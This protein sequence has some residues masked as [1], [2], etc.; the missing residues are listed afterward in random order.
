MKNTC[1]KFGLPIALLTIGST[2]G[3]EPAEQSPTVEQKDENNYT[4]ISFGADVFWKQGSFEV[5]HPIYGPDRKY[6]GSYK[7][8]GKETTLYEGF[9]YTSERIEPNAFYG[10]TNILFAIGKSDRKGYISDQN[11]YVHGKRISHIKSGSDLWFNMDAGLGYSFQPFGNPHFLLSVFAGPGFHYER[12]LH[13]HADW[14]YAMAGF[15]IAQDLTKSLSLG[16]DFKTMYSF[17]VD[18]PH[19]ETDF[20]RKG[21]RQFCGIELG[22]PLTWHFGETRK[23][24]L[25][26]KPYLLKFNLNSPETIIGSTLALGIS[27]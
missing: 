17:N 9:R 10:I 26:F 6:L 11:L 20:E 5:H 4:R 24:D 8:Y 25:Q 15:K 1:L 16:V 27:Y 3:N 14:G 23:F 21:K 12:K 13:H 18:D 2:Y 19:H 7:V 22:T